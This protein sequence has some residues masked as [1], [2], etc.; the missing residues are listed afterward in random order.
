VIIK[1][2]EMALHRRCTSVH[3]AMVGP[4]YAGGWSV[5]QSVVSNFSR[6]SGAQ[7]RLGDAHPK[8]W[9]ER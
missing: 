9:A 5:G 3:D 6:Y 2:F 8:Q 1:F 4:G 7:V